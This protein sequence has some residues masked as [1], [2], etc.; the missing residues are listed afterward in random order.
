MAS[1][2]RVPRW[3]SR[4]FLSIR[5]RFLLVASLISIS[6]LFLQFYAHHSVTTKAPPPPQP[7]PL[8]TLP[9]APL[10]SAAAAGS[11]K[12]IILGVV[13]RFVELMTFLEAP[14]F[15]VDPAVLRH[16]LV[17]NGNPNSRCK[18]FCKVADDFVT[19]GVA[20][21]FWP[22]RPATYKVQ[23]RNISYYK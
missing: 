9:A 7:L 14:T 15:V 13:K 23:D 6:F 2:P 11:K 10:H 17:L 18:F 5:L 20:A 19:F 22:D 4:H 8:S 3:L 1:F 16:L 21:N 12:Y